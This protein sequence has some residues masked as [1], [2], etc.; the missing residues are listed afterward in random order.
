M[1][2]VGY[3]PGSKAYCA[4]NPVT[5]QVHI[6]RNIVFDEEA[7]WRW[8]GQAEMGVDTDFVIEYTTVQQSDATP[9]SPAA[10]P[11]SPGSPFVTS[12]S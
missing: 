4:Y 11:P 10:A 1:I 2:F 7:Q 6:S 8:D 3:E 5:R 9:P 12:P